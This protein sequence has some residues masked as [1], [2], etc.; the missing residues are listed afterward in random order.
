MDFYTI[1][2]DISARPAIVYVVFRLLRRRDGGVHLGIGKRFVYS[3][4]G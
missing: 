4:V 3:I 2:P 1:F